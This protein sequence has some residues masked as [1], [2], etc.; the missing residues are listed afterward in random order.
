MEGGVEIMMALRVRL[1]V[2]VG[3]VAVA[4]FLVMHAAFAAGNS[5]DNKPGCGWG[6]KNHVH[7]CPPGHS[8]HQ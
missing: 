1:L 3:M 7:T 8:Q 2:T 4:A 5:G 6:D